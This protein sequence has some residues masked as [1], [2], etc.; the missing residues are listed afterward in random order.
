MGGLDQGRRVSFSPLSPLFYGVLYGCKWECNSTQN[1]PY[2]SWLSI[3]HVL[4]LTVQVPT[5]GFLFLLSCKKVRKSTKKYKKKKQG[6]PD[7]SPYSIHL[8]RNRYGG[9][10]ACC[11]HLVVQNRCTM[12]T[13]CACSHPS[14]AKDLPLCFRST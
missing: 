5:R 9:H 1:A 7:A 13:L 11:L 12:V 6:F 2:L 8:S 14:P 3:W 10:V 4:G